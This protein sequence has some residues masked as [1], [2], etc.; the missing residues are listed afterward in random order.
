M[1]RRGGWIP[2][3][4]RTPPGRISLAPLTVSSWLYDFIT[5]AHGALYRSG[6]RRRRRLG[7]RVV[8][9]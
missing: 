6:L 9:I 3:P 8:S 4:T 7:S 2:D 1:R 5:W